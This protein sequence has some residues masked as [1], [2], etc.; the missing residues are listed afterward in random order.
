MLADSNEKMMPTLPER[1]ASAIWPAWVTCMKRSGLRAMAARS[2]AMS[3]SVAAKPS[4]VSPSVCLIAVR[5]LARMRAAVALSTIGS[6]YSGSAMRF[7]SSTTAWR[8]RRPAASSLAS[9]GEVAA[10]K[11]SARTP[12]RFGFMQDVIDSAIQGQVSAGL[13]PARHCRQIK[14]G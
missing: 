6:P 7:P 13:A 10:A 12:R 9:A 8:N 14:L 2:S 11:P 5:P 4:L 1:F 3:L